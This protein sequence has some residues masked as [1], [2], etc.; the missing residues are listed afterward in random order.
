MPGD[1]SILLENNTEISHCKSIKVVS[2]GC[3]TGNIN[4]LLWIPLS[5][6]GT[7]GCFTLD[8][9]LCMKAQRP[10]FFSMEN[11]HD[12]TPGGQAN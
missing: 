7:P 2:G 8:T 6:H 9:V 5:F 11:H 3:R 10:L 12:N 4:Y 1:E